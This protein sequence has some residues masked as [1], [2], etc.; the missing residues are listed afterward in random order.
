MSVLVKRVPEE[1]PNLAVTAYAILVATVVLTPVAAWQWS[2]IRLSQLARPEIWGGVLYLGVVSTAGAFYL[3]NKGLQM[4]AAGSGGVYFFL[5]P[6]VGTLLGWLII[7]ERV[8]GWFWLGAALV[9]SGV[10]LVLGEEVDGAAPSHTSSL[11]FALI[12][13][14]SPKQLEQTEHDQHARRADI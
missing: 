1:Y 9:A 8:S 14:P 3:W 13:M 10:L 5:Q 12:L 7:G 4:V 11:Q 6:I 2:G